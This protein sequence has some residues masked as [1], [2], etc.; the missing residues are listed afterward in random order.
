[1]KRQENRKSCREISEGLELHKDEADA[2]ERLP[3]CPIQARFPSPSEPDR[4]GPG[5]SPDPLGNVARHPLRQLLLAAPLN[6][7]I[8][9]WSSRSLS[10]CWG[11]AGLSGAALRSAVWPQSGSFHPQ[12]SYLRKEPKVVGFIPPLSWVIYATQTLFSAII[13][14]FAAQTWAKSYF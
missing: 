2:H 11:D 10:E 7:E 9:I 5:W 4:T 3:S 13:R 8:H 14:H 12:L 6:Q 1:M